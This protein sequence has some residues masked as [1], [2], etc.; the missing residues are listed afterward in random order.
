[1]GVY[2]QESVQIIVMRVVFP[3]TVTEY[4]LHAYLIIPLPL[5]SDKNERIYYIYSS[6]TF[7]FYSCF[8]TNFLYSLYTLPSLPFLFSIF[9]ILVTLAFTSFVYFN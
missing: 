3:T 6:I 9:S 1:M 4:T 2:S 7:Y 8:T 5:K